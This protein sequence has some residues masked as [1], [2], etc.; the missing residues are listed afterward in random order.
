[1]LSDALDSGINGSWGQTLI[2]NIKKYFMGS[3]LIALVKS[4][5]IN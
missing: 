2:Q 5:F 4:I 1:M 3:S